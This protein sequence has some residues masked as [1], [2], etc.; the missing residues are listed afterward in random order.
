VPLFPPSSRGEGWV[1]VWTYWLI[2]LCALIAIA[3]GFAMSGEGGFCGIAVSQAVRDKQASGRLEF[4]LNRYQTFL[5]ALVVVLRRS[6]AGAP[7]GRRCGRL[8]GSKKKSSSDRTSRP[9]TAAYA[10]FQ[11][12]AANAAR[13]RPPCGDVG[14][15]SHYQAALC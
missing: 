2:V 4:W 15:L 8:N 13:A 6:S 5:G 1:P 11:S 14:P 7:S 9:M 10:Q 3:L 12:K